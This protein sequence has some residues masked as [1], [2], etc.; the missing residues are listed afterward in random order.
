[1]DLSPFPNLAD[2]MS[3]NPFRVGQLIAKLLHLLPWLN[4][5]HLGDVIVIKTLGMIRDEVE[6]LFLICHGT[7]CS[8]KTSKEF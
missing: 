6:D 3:V 8:T 5:R 7:N 4:S 1:V 2:G